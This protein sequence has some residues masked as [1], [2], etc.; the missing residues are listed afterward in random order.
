[1]RGWLVAMAVIL[2][3][4][5]GC[6]VRDVA[7]AETVETLQ[8]QVHWLRLSQNRTLEQIEALTQRTTVLLR[9][10]EAQENGT[11]LAGGAVPTLPTVPEGIPVSPPAY[12]QPE[13]TVIPTTSVSGGY[14]TGSSGGPVYVRGYTRRDG[15]YVRPHTRSR[16]R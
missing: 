13:D 16:P 10:L 3:G 11:G 15:T 14:S 7:S 1:M 12:P 2:S 8:T 9:R 4:L 6:A 5:A